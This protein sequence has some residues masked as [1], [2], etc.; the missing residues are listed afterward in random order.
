M[1]MYP[2]HRLGQAVITLLGVITLV[3]VIQRWTSTP[4]FLPAQYLSFMGDVLRLD[5]GRSLTQN[6]TVLGMI[7]GRL[8]NTLALAAG[9]LLVAAAV[10]I[11]LGAALARCRGRRIA[12]PLSWLLLAAQSMPVFWSGILLVMV[13]VVKLAWLPA[14]TAGGISQLVMPSI[15]LGLM[16][17]VSVACMTR[18]I[19]LQKWSRAEVQAVPAARGW[20]RVARTG[21]GLELSMLLTG[22]VVLEALFAWPGLGQLAVQAVLQRDFPVVRGLVLLGA[23]VAIVLHLAIDVLWRAGSDTADREMV[24]AHPG[25]VDPLANPRPSRR[26]A[27]IGPA[28]VLA[29][30][31][32]VAIL[33]PFIA[34]HDPTAQN[35]L[36]RLRPPGT[37]AGE[38]HYLL[39]S[40]E[41]GRDLFSR[42]IWGARVSLLV[43]FV[44]VALSILVGAV[45]G[46]LAAYVR[47][48]G[49]VIMQLVDIFRSVPAI[50]LAMLTLAV[51]GPSL[52]GL[53][54]VL[55]LAL[56]P[57]YA[58][59]AHAKILLSRQAGAGPSAPADANATPV[60]GHVRPG[61]LRAVLVAAALDVGFVVLFE[62]SLAFL[63]LGV[64][65]PAPSWGAMLSQGANYMG[66]AWWLAIFPG[67]CLFVLVFFANLLGDAL[68]DPAPLSAS[69]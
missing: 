55:V 46:A 41:L 48:V 19:L 59:V 6:E 38:L 26:S 20:R 28:L 36:G 7:A 53:I 42:L 12:R 27:W 32:I 34:P 35:L 51:I 44:S 25:G 24:D 57:R 9:A 30:M 13:F 5:F 3:Y 67:L 50:L 16:G 14:S 18:G 15:A 58:R 65:P 40:D 56:W 49:L 1:R 10:G 45:L 21:S 4:L 33:A 54:V 62:S 69:D 61:V 52:Q 22:V 8:P 63:G 17:M 37:T 47:G 68:R 31:V 66:S 29:A 23:M 39:G 11:P 60:R 64:Q 2:W 43:A